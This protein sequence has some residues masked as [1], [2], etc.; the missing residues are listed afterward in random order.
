MNASKLASMSVAVR[1]PSGAMKVNIGCGTSGARGWHN[2]DNSP[3]IWLAKIPLA[4]KILHFPNWPDDVRWHNVL[5]GL[6]FPDLSVDCIYSSHTFEHFTFEQCLKVAK[7][8]WRVLTTKGI[9]RVA[10]PDLR[11]A[12]KDYLESREPMASHEFVDRLLMSRGLQDLIHRGRHHHQ[13]FDANSLGFLFREAGFL[14]P[15]VKQ[16][17]E[18]AIPD[19]ADVELESRKSESVYVEALKSPCS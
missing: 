1:Q 11:I 8:C 2:F 16:F 15:K 19:I 3:S 17:R 10:V 18:S 7:E 5:N 13:M 14:Q 4:K 6:P 12:I 9:L